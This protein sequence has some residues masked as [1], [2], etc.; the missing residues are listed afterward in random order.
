MLEIMSAHQGINHTVHEK[1][2]PEEQIGKLME[3]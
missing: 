2:M 1:T 3:Q